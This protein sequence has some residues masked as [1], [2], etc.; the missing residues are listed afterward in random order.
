MCRLQREV[1]REV[2]EWFKLTNESTF[3]NVATGTQHAGIFQDWV[4]KAA[5]KIKSINYCKGIYVWGLRALVAVC[6]VCI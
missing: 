2:T 6:L 3:D 4:P 1:Y 5:I